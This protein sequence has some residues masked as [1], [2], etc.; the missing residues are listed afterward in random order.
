MDYLDVIDDMELS[1]LLDFVGW[2]NSYKDMLISYDNLVEEAEF[3][4]E[5]KKEDEQLK[6]MEENKNGY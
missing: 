1:E 6:R 3:K 2:R 4:A 5:C